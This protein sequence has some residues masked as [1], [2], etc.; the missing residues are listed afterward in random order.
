MAM[1][2]TEVHPALVHFPLTLFPLALVADLLGRR[3]HRADLSRLGAWGIKAAAA[4]AATAGLFGFVAQEEV[5]TEDPRALATLQTHRTLNLM[6]VVALGAMAVYR[7]RRP[8]AT[9]GYLATGCGVLG[10]MLYSAYLGGEMVYTSGLGVEPADGLY[11][12]VPELTPRTA[13]RAA[14]AAARD[15][16]K[17]VAHTARDM[18]HGEFVPAFGRGAARPSGTGGARRRRATME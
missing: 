1:R 17:G 12:E 4:A 5:N 6:G 3:G 2:L 13:G 10:A 11:G 16:G 8:R 18:A 15:L 14:L 7:H 9:P